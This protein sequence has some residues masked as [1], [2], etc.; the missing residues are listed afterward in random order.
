[1]AGGLEDCREMSI[2]KHIPIRYNII[3]VLIHFEKSNVFFFTPLPC[4]IYGDSTDVYDIIYY[5]VPIYTHTRILGRPSGV[6]S[7]VAAGRPS[8]TLRRLKNIKQCPDQ[9]DDDDDGKKSV[10]GEEGD[11]E[12]KKKER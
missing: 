10:G 6:S 7:A 12:S 9:D 4:T 11:M 3:T 1:M 5:C 8:R 2:F